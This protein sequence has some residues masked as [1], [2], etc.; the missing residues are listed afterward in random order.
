[1]STIT[2][3][4]AVLGAGC[5]TSLTAPAATGTARALDTDGWAT[6][7]VAY[8][9]P[10][11]TAAD[12][13]FAVG[14]LAFSAATVNV[15]PA[16]GEDGGG[17]AC[18][19]RTTTPTGYYD[20]SDNML[21]AQVTGRVECNFAAPWISFTTYFVVTFDA[22]NPRGTRRSGPTTTCDWS[23][24]RCTGG[25]AYYNV[26]T[27]SGR[28]DHYGTIY[29]QYR[30]PDGRTHSIANAG[31]SSMGGHNAGQSMSQYC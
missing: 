15:T 4:L 8:A 14:G 21:Y 2:I 1:M 31:S 18:V 9:A 11:E 30:T 7:G 19:G 23:A 20:R 26:T 16:A 13:A 25:V 3:R 29:G 28:Y 24:T 27:C 10:A 17:Y 22:A 5:L 12:T 6:Y